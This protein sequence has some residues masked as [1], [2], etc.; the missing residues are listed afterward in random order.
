MTARKRKPT[1]RVDVGRWTL[2]A[3]GPAHVLIPAV[4]DVCGTAF[5]IEYDNRS[6]AVRVPVSR[7]HDLV[8]ALEARGANVDV[9]GEIP[10]PELFP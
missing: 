3:R 4:R 10:A 7:A 6:R 1:V 9:R 5:T 8:A 2:E